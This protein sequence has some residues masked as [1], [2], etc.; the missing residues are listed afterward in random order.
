M[1]PRNIA[2]PATR[3]RRSI[4]GC[5]SKFARAEVELDD[6]LCR[7]LDEALISRKPHKGSRGGGSE[8][9]KEHIKIPGWRRARLIPAGADVR[10]QERL[11]LVEALRPQVATWRGARPAFRSRI[12]PAH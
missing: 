10:R 7:R 8:I 11:S 6:D 2:A 9:Y 4:M 1:Q 12:S 3:S 5:L